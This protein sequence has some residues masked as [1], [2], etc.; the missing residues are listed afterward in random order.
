MFCVIAVYILCVKLSADSISK[1]F[2]TASARFCLG[3][4]NA[5]IGDAFF[6][7]FSDKTAVSVKFKHIRFKAVAD[8]YRQTAAGEKCTVGK[9]SQ[10]SRSCCALIEAIAAFKKLQGTIQ[11]YVCIAE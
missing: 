4:G 1:A 5:F 8:R 7:Q 3:A 9:N 10:Q 6:F 11:V 2:C